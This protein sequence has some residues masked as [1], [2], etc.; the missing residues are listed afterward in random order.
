MPREHREL[1]ADA[2]AP[3]LAGLA[4]A[5]LAA[6]AGF[7]PSGGVLVALFVLSAV[8]VALAQQTLP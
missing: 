4:G 5:G 3:L 2:S 8:V 6:L 7:A 1:L